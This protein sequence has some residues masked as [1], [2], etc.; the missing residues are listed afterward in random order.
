MKGKAA[1]LVGAA[2]GYVL[3]TRDGRERYEQIKAKASGMWQDPKVQQK[4]S[5]V[6]DLAKEKAPVVKD[7]VAE[8]VGGGSGSNDGS[9][10]GSSSTVTPPSSSGSG[11]GATSS[12]TGSG[13]LSG[14]PSDL[15][16]QHRPTPGGVGG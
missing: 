10:D 1:L 7:K 13:P 9:N 6:Q 3:G 16:T 15:G 14:S 4:V 2:V 8:K 12:T 11:L 5:E